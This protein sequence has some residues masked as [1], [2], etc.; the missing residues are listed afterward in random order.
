MLTNE[1]PNLMEVCFHNGEN[2]MKE[3]VVSMFRGLADSVPCVT[4]VQAI[5]MVEEL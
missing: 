5:K 2:H 4:L 1:N 3:K